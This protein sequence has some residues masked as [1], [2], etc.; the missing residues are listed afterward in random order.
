M[1]LAAFPLSLVDQD[2][3]VQY[4]SAAIERLLGYKP[5]D[6]AGAAW[7]SFLHAEDAAPV[8]S[9]FS[10]M[11]KGGGEQARWVLRFRSAG[12]DWRPVEVRA[13]N[14]LADPDVGGVLLTLRAV[15]GRRG[16]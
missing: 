13:R 8:Q 3:T 16:G 4:Q 10:E 9:Q 14:L 11:V 1:K 12:G 6:V 5:E 2:G 7:F 15:P